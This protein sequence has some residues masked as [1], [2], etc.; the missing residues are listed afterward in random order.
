MSP[1]ERLSRWEEEIKD[2]L[3]AAAFVQLWMTP[4]VI[5]ADTGEATGGEEWPVQ[6]FH[7]SWLGQR[8]RLTTAAVRRKTKEQSRAET[9]R[10]WTE[11]LA[12]SNGSELLRGEDTRTPAQQAEEFARSFVKGCAG[13]LSTFVE[14]AGPDGVTEFLRLGAL[15][16]SAKH[17]MFVE[18][19]AETRAVVRGVLGL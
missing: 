2:E 15:R 4:I 1:H 13:S 10:A 3:A 11:F 18:R 6:R 16:R 5:N 19:A 14:L 8:L 17:R 9:D 12:A 7:A